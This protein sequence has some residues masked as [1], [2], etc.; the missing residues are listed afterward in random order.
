[1]ALPGNKLQ[2]ISGWEYGGNLAFVTD[3]VRIMIREVEPRFAVESDGSVQTKQRIIRYT[4]AVP[5]LCGIREGD[6]VAELAEDER[7]ACHVYRVVEVGLDRVYPDSFEPTA[8][9]VWHAGRAVLWCVDN[10][11]DEEARDFQGQ[12]W[13]CMVDKLRSEEKNPVSS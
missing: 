5:E 6:L 3:P 10:W 4:L 11:D 13:P 1:M 8:M 12:A 2:G 9:E 7:T